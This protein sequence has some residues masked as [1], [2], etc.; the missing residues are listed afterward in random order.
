MRDT[1][2]CQPHEYFQI[3]QK[4]LSKAL[5][6]DIPARNDIVNSVYEQMKLL[7]A[8]IDYAFVKDGV[9]KIL[10]KEGYN[11]NVVYEPNPFYNPNVQIIVKGHSKIGERKVFI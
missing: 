7:R 8:D 10:D 4:Y 6:S 9:L 1:I 2:Y 11:G 3:K 5:F